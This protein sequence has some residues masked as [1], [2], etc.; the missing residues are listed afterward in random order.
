MQVKRV[1]TREMLED[2]GKRCR[3]QWKCV[4]SCDNNDIELLRSGNKKEKEEEEDQ[5][6]EAKLRTKVLFPKRNYQKLFRYKIDG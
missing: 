5:K 6:K 1:V 2:D 3:W 4:S